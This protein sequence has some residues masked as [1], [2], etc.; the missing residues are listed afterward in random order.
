M[1]QS[2]IQDQQLEKTG[3][4]EK[5]RFNRSFYAKLALSAPDVKEYYSQVVSKL[6]SYER[7][8]TR[9]YWSGIAF[10]VGNKP[11]ARLGMSGK[12]LCIYL[13]IDEDET[14]KKYKAKDVSDKKKY[15]KVP[16]LYKIKSKGALN[17]V[18]RMIEKVASLLS[19]TE[20]SDYTGASVKSVPSDTFDNLL[21]K[22]FIKRIRAGEKKTNSNLPPKSIFTTTDDVYLDTSKTLG[23][24]IS[25][26]AEYGKIADM[27][28]NGD[29]RVKFS[30]KVM[31]RSIDEAWLKA[32]EDCL[33]AIDVLVRNPSHFIAESEKVLPI[34]L[35][36]RVTGRAVTHLC[37]HTDFL[38][39]NEN[40]ELVPTKLL[41][42]FRDDSL[43][44][45]ENKF[46]NTLL[47]R[48]Y[49]FVTR[50]YDIAE[51]YGA[52]EK[53]KMME[54][55]DTFYHDDSK[56]RIT[57]KVELSD[58]YE[59]KVEV[60]RSAYNA[61]L[62]KR[63]KKVKD[64]VSQ[65][66]DSEFV[67]D[68]GKSY[69]NPPILRTNAILKNKNF[70][71]CLALWDFIEGY[72][73]AIGLT[74][75]E[76]VSEIDP[77][78]AKRL[79]DLASIEYLLFRYNAYGSLSNDKAEETYV[80]QIPNPR[81]ITDK[82]EFEDGEFDFEFE[83]EPLV[84]EDQ[85]IPLALD[86]AMQADIEY[87]KE[88][89]EDY[90]IY[91]EDY[92]EA[93][94]YELKDTTILRFPAK[95]RLSD[96]FTKRAYLDIVNEFL[97]YRRVS[98]RESSSCATI[99]VGRKA[100]VKL[101]IRGKSLYA[102]FSVDG[103]KFLP[104][105]HLKLVDA[106][107]YQDVPSRMRVRSPRALKYA[108]E[109]AQ[110]IIEREELKEKKTPVFLSRSE[111]KALSSEEMLEKGWIK[112]KKVK[113]EVQEPDTPT[114]ELIEEKTPTIEI[115]RP[116]EKTYS[117]VEELGEDDASDFIDYEEGPLETGKKRKSFAI[118]RNRKSDKK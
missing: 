64:A 50:R 26:Y 22:G 117:S 32:I 77:E 23:D 21:T 90:G 82:E 6:F 76:K 74:I 100:V 58:P 45:Y 31:L 9:V 2:N 67:K 70:R 37:R 13:P 57:I 102:Y 25:E 17:N 11:L 36:K 107:K 24:L 47:S 109:I 49:I 113:V 79:Y 108:L 7:T 98:F 54:F 116:D 88:F 55:V 61:T 105:Y 56:G 97:K 103:S 85:D 112:N 29:G 59:E 118:F 33:P 43:L 5:I 3:W 12:T 78:Y 42:V 34:E 89:P 83:D 18:L 39:K 44:T 65:Y 92:S 35:T 15:Q 14:G 20:K 71:Q 80:H 28:T 46:L 114:E 81:I 101:A 111:L 73:D 51:D 68:M 38:A 110:F 95:I 48:L 27:L 52:D 94:Y 86:V 84:S 69:V 16:S 75:T 4:T 66:M 41:N 93:T 30:E 10:Y 19:L 8:R 60:K 63:V 1:N 99:R 96:E 115:F 91:E 104:K 40:D 106:K 72:E 62:K 87:R 53:V